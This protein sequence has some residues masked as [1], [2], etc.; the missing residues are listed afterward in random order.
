MYTIW[1]LANEL[2]VADK[3]SKDKWIIPEFKPV[4]DER[5]KEIVEEINRLIREWNNEEDYE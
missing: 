3:L 2:Y 5:I 1:F 4:I